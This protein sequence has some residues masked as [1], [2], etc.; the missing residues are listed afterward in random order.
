MSPIAR[1]VQILLAGI[2]STLSACSPV[3]IINGLTP[4]NTYHLSPDIPYQSQARGHLDVYT[5]LPRDGYP[6][7]AG[8]YPVVLFLFGGAWDSGSRQEYK[9]VGEALAARGIV[10]VIP[11]Y[12]LYPEVRYPSFLQDN[13][14]AVAWTYANIGQYGGNIHDFYL[15]GHSAGAYNAAMLVLDPRWL[16]AVGLKPD[17]FQGWIGLAGPYNFYPITYKPIRPI[18]HY[19]NYPAQSMPIDFA[20]NPNVPRT[21]LGAAVQ[22]SLVNPKVNTEVLAKALEKAGVSVELRR[23]GRVNH[24]TLIG[25]FAKPLRWMAPVLDD[26]VAF[27]KRGQDPHTTN[28]LSSH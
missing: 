7:P 21:F 17:I 13:A 26:V 22:D 20:H 6:K 28:K 5:P 1:S 18:F 24:E 3:Q 2:T 23:Y 4:S 15:M 11:N 25:A 12:R 27:I 10:V 14:R 16:A 19:P 9:F 8:G